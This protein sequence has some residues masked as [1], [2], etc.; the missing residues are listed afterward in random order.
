M[1]QDSIL[2]STHLNIGV[3][4]IVCWDGNVLIVF[5]MIFLNIGEDNIL[6]N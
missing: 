3:F 2:P 5:V 6:F 4:F 1:L